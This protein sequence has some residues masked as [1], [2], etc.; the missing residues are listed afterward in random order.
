MTAEELVLK[1]SFLFEFEELCA[2]YSAT[3]RVDME[4]NLYAGTMYVD[5][6]QPDEKPFEFYLL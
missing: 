6:A 5:V 2:K 1:D 4:G 3:V